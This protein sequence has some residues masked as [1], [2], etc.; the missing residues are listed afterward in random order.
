MTAHSITKAGKSF[1]RQSIR[2][3]SKI[4]KKEFGDKLKELVVDEEALN[5]FYSSSV[6]E[7]FNTNDLSFKIFPM[8]KLEEGKKLLNEINGR[9][10]EYALNAMPLEDSRQMLAMFDSPNILEAK[11]R[12]EMASLPDK[13]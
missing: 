8:G 3:F 12:A 10:L 5:L 7:S 6:L 9:A 2:Y 11:R 4:V 13:I 1:R